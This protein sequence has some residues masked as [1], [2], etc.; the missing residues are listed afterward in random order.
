MQNEFACLVHGIYTIILD[1][2]SSVIYLDG[3]AADR[4]LV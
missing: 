3:L 1:L 4:K 2:H